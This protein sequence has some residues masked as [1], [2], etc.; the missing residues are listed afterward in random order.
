MYSSHLS[1]SHWATQPKGTAVHCTNS[2]ASPH[3]PLEWLYFAQSL[4]DLVLTLVIIFIPIIIILSPF[5]PLLSLP[6]PQPNILP[7]SPLP[8]FDSVSLS[9]IHTNS[10][11]G[12][13]NSPTTPSSHASCSAHSASTFPCVHQ[14]HQQLSPSA[15]SF[16]VPLPFTYKCTVII[17][18]SQPTSPAA[19]PCCSLLLRWEKHL[20]TPT[21]THDSDELLCHASQAICPDSLV[22]FTA[23]SPVTSVYIKASSMLATTQYGF[24][25]TE[26]GGLRNPGSD[27]FL[28][29]R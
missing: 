10:S 17:P 8:A 5:T 24:F 22:E 6:L 1:W 27:R 9:V 3:L 19:L 26:R 18:I 7:F 14:V 21:W 15:C 25:I 13:P 12:S 29:S 28:N 16:I 20:P 23:R 4:H 11:K 2:E